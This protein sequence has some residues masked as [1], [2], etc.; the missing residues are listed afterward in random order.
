MADDAA[1][2]PTKSE[3]PV[4]DT[5]ASQIGAALGERLDKVPIV[6]L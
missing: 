5:G 3:A 6:W 2:T 1:A 4:G